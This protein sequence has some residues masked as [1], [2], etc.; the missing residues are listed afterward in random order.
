MKNDNL[1]INEKTGLVTQYLT[2]TEQNNINVGLYGTSTTSSEEHNGHAGV[3][4]M[5]KIYK[6]A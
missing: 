4:G 5:L 3:N 2:L 1:R 6:Y